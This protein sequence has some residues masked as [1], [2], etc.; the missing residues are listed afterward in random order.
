MRFV[1]I[2]IAVAL[3]SPAALAQDPNTLRGARAQAESMVVASGPVRA[4]PS[5]TYTRSSWR[6]NRDLAGSYRDVE[7]RHR[8]TRYTYGWPVWYNYW[9]R[10]GSGRHACAA[11]RCW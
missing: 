11:Y 3:A 5:Q 2:L 8:F 10:F 6:A 9:T 1:P 7:A 4:A